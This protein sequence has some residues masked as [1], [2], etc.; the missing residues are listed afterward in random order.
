MS[1]LLAVTVYDKLGNVAAVLE[2]LQGSTV[3]D[4]RTQANRRQC[5]L[6]VADP[7]GVFSPSNAGS[8]LAT[9]STSGYI[10]TVST[11]G[12]ALGTFIVQ[13]GDAKDTG[14]TRTVTVTGVDLSWLATAY[15]FQSTWTVPAGQPWSWA[16]ADL[17][18]EYIPQLD[19]TGLAWVPWPTPAIALNPGDEAWTEMATDWGPALGYEL[20]VDQNN[21]GQLQLVPDPRLQTP[22]FTFVEGQNCQMGAVE[23]SFTDDSCP[24]AFQRDGVGPGNAVVTAYAADENPN[25]SSWVGIYGT[26][27]DYEQDTLIASQAQADNAVLMQLYLG[28]GANEPVVLTLDPTVYALQGVPLAGQMALVTRAAAGLTDA[29]VVMDSI[30]HSFFPGD[31]PTVTGRRI[32][33]WT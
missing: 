25:S 24:N 14:D 12:L 10:I 17:L 9:G 23:H 16:I 21:V 20:Y 15:P 6:Q 3:T 13:T 33:R 11:Y 18:Q 31:T 1:S 19:L 28:L 8:L 4:D 5:N 30:V 32:G 27:L 2:C 7:Y 22:S 26:R 29:Y